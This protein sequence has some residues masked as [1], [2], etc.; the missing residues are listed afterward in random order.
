MPDL[1]GPVEPGTR[2]P[3]KINSL[4]QNFKINFYIFKKKSL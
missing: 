2:G 3:R 4:R 1:D